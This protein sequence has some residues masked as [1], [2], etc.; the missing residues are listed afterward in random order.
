MASFL[1]K[2]VSLERRKGSPKFL[3]MIVVFTFLCNVGTLYLNQIFSTVF[4]NPS[5]LHECAVGFSGVIFALK[6]VAT[7]DTPAGTTYLMGFIPVW[8]RYACWAELLLI[9]VMVPNVS[10][11]GHLAGILVGMVYVKGP[12]KSIMD[13]VWN[14]IF[15]NRI[16]D[17]VT[18][19]FE[20]REPAYTY[21]RGT[22]GGQ[23]NEFSRYTN[24]LSEEEQLRRATEESLRTNTNSRFNV[25]SHRSNPPYPN[26]N[27]PAYSPNPTPN[28]Y[29]D[30]K[31]EPSAPP[32]E[33]PPPPGWNLSPDHDLLRRRR[34]EHYDR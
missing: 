8:S 32:E 33:Q 14:V 30:L 2:G 5:Y 4:D 6:V 7:H 16:S 10:F 17:T 13:A 28:M 25:Q 19:T 20:G 15:N 18:R 34:L 23:H 24:G 3:Y 31:P 12:L 9:Q 22:V 26:Y 1:W 27:S 21:T 11:T 29:P